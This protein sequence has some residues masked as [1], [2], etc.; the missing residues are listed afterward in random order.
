MKNKGF[1]LIELMAVITILAILT[2]IIVP[3]VDKNI[4][5]AKDVEYKMQIE[6]IKIAAQNYYIDNI[7]LR[8]KKGESDE[9]ELS[10]LIEKNY[11]EDFDESSITKEYTKEEISVIIVNDDGKYSYYVC[12]LEEEC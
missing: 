2:L 1:T 5:K 8:P 6:N 11:I 4:K 7:T 3:I 12:P 9:V 10:E